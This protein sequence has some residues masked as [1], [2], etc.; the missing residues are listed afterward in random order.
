MENV[1][2]REIFTNNTLVD[3]ISYY[4]YQIL[5]VNRKVLKDL[6]LSFFVSVD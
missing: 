6:S 3:V 1:I 5:N 4:F 2:N